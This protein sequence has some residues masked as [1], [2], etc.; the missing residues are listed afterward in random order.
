MS[1]HRPG[2]AGGEWQLEPGSA[3]F[4]SSSEWTP[5]HLHVYLLGA[6]SVGGTGCPGCPSAAATASFRSLNMFE[7]H[8]CSMLH[9]AG[10]LSFQHSCLLSA[11]GCSRRATAVCK[12]NCNKKLDLASPKCTIV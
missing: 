7:F 6:F 10:Q 8:T 4:Q 2:L 3:D 11:D 9:V 12:N 5:V 1:A